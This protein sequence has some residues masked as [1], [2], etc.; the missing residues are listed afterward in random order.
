MYLYDWEKSKQEGMFVQ[1]DVRQS[2]EYCKEIILDCM[3]DEGYGS[4]QFCS[5]HWR[6]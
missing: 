3:I 5:Q 2:V 1:G 4:F 6:Y